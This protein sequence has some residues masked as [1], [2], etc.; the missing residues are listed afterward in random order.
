MCDLP[1]FVILVT[2]SYS[3]KGNENT[4]KMYF[5]DPALPKDSH[6]TIFPHHTDSTS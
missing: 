6:T 3:V 4:L 5:L 1:T 2:L